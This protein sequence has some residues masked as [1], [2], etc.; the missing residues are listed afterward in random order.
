[1]S[2]LEIIQLTG[3]ATGSILH[4]WIGWLLSRQ[5]HRL[6][7]KKKIL[8]ALAISVGVW[9]ASNLVITLHGLLISDYSR[10]TNLLRLADSFAVVSITLTYSFL[11][12]VHLYLWA[13]T[14]SRSLTR[15]ETLRVFLSYVPAIFLIIAIPHIW[16]EPY[17]RMFEKMTSVDWSFGKLNM[18]FAF[19]LWA[20]YVLVLIGIT[21]LLIARSSKSSTEKRLMRA[22]AISFIVIAC[23]IL[24]V[25]GFRIGQASLMEKYLETLTNL[26]SLLPSA[27]I[28]YYVYRYRYLELII[29]ESLVVASFAV[30][31]LIIYLYGI[32]TLG[33]T[34]TTLYGLRTG[35]VESLMILILA[36]VAAPIRNW[37]EK[38]F[39]N[40][41]KR[42]TNVY[43]EVVATISEK[44]GD[45]KYLP[46][47][48]KS[49][50]NK[51]AESLG[52]RRI[53]ILETIRKRIGTQGDQ[54][55][56]DWVDN[57]LTLLHKN[58]WRPLEHHEYLITYSYN[59]VYALHRENVAVGLMLVEAE[60][61]VLTEEVKAVLEILANHL[62]VAIEDCRLVEE[63]VELERR[64]ARGERLAALGQMATTVAHEV[65]NPLSA[66]KSIAQVMGEDENLQREYGRD[67]DLIIKEVDRLNRSVMQ[68]MDFARYS[69]QSMVRSKINE[70]IQ[71]VIDLFKT[72][73]SQ[74]SIQLEHKVNTT[75]EVEGNC[76]VAIRDALSNLI[77]NG[78]QAMPGGGRLIVEAM[79]E[80]KSLVISIIDTGPGIDVELRDRIWEPFFTTKQRGT[81]LGLA[82]VQKRLEDVGGDIVLAPQ[83]SNEGARFILRVPTNNH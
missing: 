45:Y 29:Q 77:L 62:T 57:V 38:R 1:M 79:L 9:H 69:P 6:N 10:W 37:L 18:V 32:L 78:I 4:L 5:Y 70:L 55:P 20:F 15:F 81:G 36:L 59:M 56:V 16:T 2:F 34:L 80:G 41:F 46:I 48:L 39:R 63:N 19:A 72:E 8:L 58:E 52:L 35:V 73:A 31:V 40:I 43:R 42:E 7:A 12:H 30:V 76:L 82:I 21:D 49:V 60:D 26:G 28:A 23:M 33:Q 75:I 14:R 13:D 50:G 66:I 25:V 44:R 11:L 71:N 74:Q 24:V 68:L 51:I 47:L 83:R 53:T 64:L 61:E 27:L 67:I 3:Y 54:L 65:K 17:A 22:L